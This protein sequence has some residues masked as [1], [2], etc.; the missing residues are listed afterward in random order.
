MTFRNWCLGSLTLLSL[1]GFAGA[2]RASSAR[3]E[4]ATAS[5]NIEGTWLGKSPPEAVKPG[6]RW[7]PSRRFTPLRRGA[8]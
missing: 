8:P 6:R 5:K 7:E 4:S 3:T 2:I 1:L